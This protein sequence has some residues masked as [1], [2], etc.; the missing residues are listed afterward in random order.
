MK[1]V[2]VSRFIFI[3]LFK[4]KCKLHAF[5]DAS[6]VGYATVI[7]IRTL[8]NTP[9]KKTLAAKLTVSFLNKLSL[10]RFELCGAH[11]LG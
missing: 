10:S 3:N 4:S 11:L 9:T 6:V 5:Y 1:T 8:T 2:A 7:Y